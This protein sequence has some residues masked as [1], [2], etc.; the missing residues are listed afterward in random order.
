M[1]HGP[2]PMGYSP[3]PMGYVERSP[4]A[5]AHEPWPM[6]HE[7]QPMIHSGGV[8]GD[9]RRSLEISPEISGVEK[10]VKWVLKHNKNVLKEDRV[11]SL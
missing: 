4:W 2:Q 11:V 6:A 7:L 3:W 9:L 8:S 10:L 1:S 5:T